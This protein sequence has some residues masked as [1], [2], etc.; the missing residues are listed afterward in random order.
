MMSR[1]TDTP[2]QC[3]GGPHCYSHS[4]PGFL[5]A[6]VLRRPVSTRV[7]SHSFMGQ[8]GTRCLPIGVPMLPPLFTVSLLPL[9][10]LGEAC[11]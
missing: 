3:L 11:G 8:M 4:F 6:K 2:N 1:E 9:S 5:T 7:H 10:P